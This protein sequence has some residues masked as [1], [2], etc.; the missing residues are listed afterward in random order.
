MFTLRPLAAPLSARKRAAAFG[1]SAFVLLTLGAV[2]TAA[3]CS[4][5][6]DVPPPVEVVNLNVSTDLPVPGLSEDENRVFAE[7]DRLFDLPLREAD[8]I[9]PLFAHDHCSACHSN[10]LRGPGLVQKMVVVEADGYTPMQDQ[11]SKLPFGGTEHPFFNAGA[12]RG[13]LAPNGDTS[14]KLS[15]RMGPPVMGRGYLEAIAD[16]ELEA[17]L[18]EQAG[19][20]DGVHGRINQIAYQSEPNTDTRFHATKKGQYVYGRFGTKARIAYLDDFAADA[21]QGDMGITSPLRP[22]ELSNPDGLTD[23]R[24]PGVD[25][26]YD[27]VN[28][29]ADYTRLVAIPPRAR[30]SAADIKLFA[31]VT[32]ASCHTP[33]QRTRADYPFKPMAN[34]DA[35]VFTDLLIHDMGVALADGV[36][37]GAAGP[38]DWRTSPLIGLRF[39]KSYLHDGRARTIREAILAHAGDGSEANAAIQKFNALSPADQAR[40]EAY[41]LSL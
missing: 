33:T 14:I 20:S 36:V 3:A 4:S 39:L 26:G 25:V 11:I 34:I 10:A 41:V 27:S 21:F 37:E 31:D 30:P 28:K 40:L 12:T 17:R 32:C 38:R 6:G 24:K 29:R 19:R 5:P 23:D 16:S 7:G 8:G 18:V 22:V 15:T 1:R 2:G 35:P 13:V 9:G